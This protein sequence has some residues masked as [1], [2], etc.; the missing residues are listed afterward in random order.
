MNQ[1]RNIHVNECVRRLRNCKQELPW[2][3]KRN[4]LQDY[5]IRMFHGGYDEKFR[6]DVVRQSIA[7]YEGMIRADA[8]G[9]QP[10]YRDRDWQKTERRKQKNKKKDNWLAKGGYDTVIMVPSTPGGK[11]A[12]MYKQ[13][14]ESNP[15]PV[16]IK[17]QESGGL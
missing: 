14:I 12:E 5:V 11:L 15:G 3:V 7:R 13:V 16:K 4:F 6:H 8:D 9:H 10:L 17:V 2:S 1:K